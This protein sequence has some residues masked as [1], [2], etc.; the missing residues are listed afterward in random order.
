MTS[1]RSFSGRE[2]DPTSLQLV[3]LAA[4]SFARH[5]FA[6]FPLTFTC[7]PHLYGRAAGE[8]GAITQLS[9]RPSAPQ[10]PSSLD[11]NAQKGRGTLKAS[12]ACAGQG[13]LA[14][15]YRDPR[16]RSESSVEHLHRTSEAWKRPL[17]SD[18]RFAHPPPRS[19][20][21][22]GR[23]HPQIKAQSAVKVQV[24][25]YRQVADVGGSLLVRRSCASES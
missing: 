16:R 15:E 3:P 11:N 9:R 23:L 4:T 6:A 1:F 20:A 5:R 12:R 24:L 18:L 21:Q 17:T 2:R 8:L 10:Q 7:R 14:N 19:T 22:D 13:R 25:I